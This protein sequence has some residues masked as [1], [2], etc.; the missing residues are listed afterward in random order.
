MK[1]LR[2]TFTRVPIGPELGLKPV[3]AIGADWAVTVAVVVAVFV[4]PVVSVTVTETWN[5]PA[6][7]Y[8]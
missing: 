6:A 1:L 3:I 2:V 7:V 5:V 8:V 4:P